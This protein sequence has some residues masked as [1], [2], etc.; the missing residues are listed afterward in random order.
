MCCLQQVGDEEWENLAQ[1]K[2]RSNLDRKVIVELPQ[3]TIA[4]VLG[5]FRSCQY[6]T[7]STT[8]Q[9]VEAHSLQHLGAAM[10]VLVA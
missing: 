8:S 4:D 7:Q 6:R 9:G 10:V 5:N 3:K 2:G 1:A